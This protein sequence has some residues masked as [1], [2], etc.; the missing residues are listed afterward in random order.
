MRILKKIM[1]AALAMAI[2]MPLAACGETSSTKTP[3]TTTPAPPAETAQ[4]EENE[5][6]APPDDEGEATPIEIQSS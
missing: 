2:A 1:A 3:A 4:I 6:T 5:P